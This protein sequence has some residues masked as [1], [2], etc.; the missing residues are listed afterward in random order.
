MEPTDGLPLTG[1]IHELTLTVPDGLASL[2]FLDLSKDDLTGLTLPEGLTSLT[3][4]DLWD[5]PIEQLAMPFSLDLDGLNLRGFSKDRVIF[6][7]WVSLQD[8][9]LLWSHGVLEYARDLSGPW[10]EVPVAS[11]F[12]FSPIGERGFF[13]LKMEE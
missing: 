5:N 8:G 4:L 12:Q 1:R 13:R 3:L 9:R 10:G 11:P 7:G 2:T 6:P